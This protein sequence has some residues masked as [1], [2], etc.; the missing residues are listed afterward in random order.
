M[1]LETLNGTLWKFDKNK[2]IDF[3]F[4][5]QSTTE[6]A[7]QFYVGSDKR[8]HVGYE[9]ITITYN[10]LTDTATYIITERYVDEY[11]VATVNYTTGIV[12]TPKTE[13]AD[14]F[15]GQIVRITG[16]SDCADA[17]A[18][19][20]V[21]TVANQLTSLANTMW[22]I[23]PSNSRTSSYSET[24]FSLDLYI[25][26]VQYYGIRYEEDS[27]TQSDFAFIDDR[28][29]ERFFLGRT[30]QKFYLDWNDHWLEMTSARGAYY[31][32][33]VAVKILGGD[34]VE[35]AD[36]INFIVD[37]ADYVS[38]YGEEKYDEYMTDIADAIREKTGITGTMRISEMAGYIRSIQVASNE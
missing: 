37:N 19:A 9:K 23:W 30:R 32:C 27:S 26:G 24:I 4:T 17:T 1:A 6:F 10:S 12:E 36:A 22:R 7:L 13:Y 11:T 8:N 14:L 31:V 18:I 5:E 34:D 20:F 21:S 29:L 35:D 28:G 3:P 25:E 2:L 38:D 33:D 16:G 15:W